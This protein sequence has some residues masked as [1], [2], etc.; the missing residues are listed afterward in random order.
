MSEIWAML[1]NGVGAGAWVVGAGLA[2]VVALPVFWA[3][4]GL[5]GWVLRGRKSGDDL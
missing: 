2:L 4:L 3:L 1:Q 5:I